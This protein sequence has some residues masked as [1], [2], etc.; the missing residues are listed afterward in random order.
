MKKAYLTPREF[1]LIHHCHINSVMKWI[2]RGWVPS[3]LIRQGKR[4]RYLIPAAARPPRRRPGPPKSADTRLREN[5]RLLLRLS[6]LLKTQADVLDAAGLLPDPK[7]ERSFSHDEGR[8]TA[9]TE[10]EPGCHDRH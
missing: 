10:G 1:A 4:V 2:H 7:K 9:H 6:R 8:R 5:T 3:A